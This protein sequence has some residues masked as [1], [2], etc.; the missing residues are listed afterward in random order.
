M[1]QSSNNTG[2]LPTWQFKMSDI[3]L[4]LLDANNHTPIASKKK[5]FRALKY[6]QDKLYS[7][8]QNP[9]LIEG[10]LYEFTMGDFGYWSIDVINDIE[11]FASLKIISVGKLERRNLTQNT[12]YI[13]G[14]GQKLLREKIY[15]RLTKVQILILSQLKDLA[16]SNSI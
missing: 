2:E 11:M 15:P 5:L 13:T 8:F 14:I 3:L 4:L 12:F 7:S 6:F 16:L 1:E 9:P 10:K